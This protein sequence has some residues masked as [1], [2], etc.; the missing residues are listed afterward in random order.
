MDVDGNGVVTDDDVNTFI[1]RYSYFY[2]RKD[3]N[4]VDQ[5]VESIMRTQ[6]FS[7]HSGTVDQLTS[8]EQACINSK[9][10]DVLTLGQNKMFQTLVDSTKDQAAKT[11]FPIEA[12][13]EEKFDHIL[14]DL[15]IKLQH[16]GMSYEDLF[17]L[18]DTDH[19]GFLSISEFQ[20]IDKILN[21]SQPA[22]DGFFAFMD[23]QKI[24]LIDQ[25][26]FVRYMG[27]SII[28]KMAGITEDDWDWEMEVLF[29]VR[30]WMQR[31]NITVEDAFRTFD[32]DF[33]G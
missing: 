32:K 18:L 4:Q 5:I 29:K 7:K 9:S 31:E 6:S 13:P 26:T 17:V 24:G 3:Q 22:K 15:R 10:I 27:K 30:N 33:D 14:R 11:L 12:L 21:L 25:N 23:K 2:V 16:K 19:N 20:N 8:V 28:K 1:K